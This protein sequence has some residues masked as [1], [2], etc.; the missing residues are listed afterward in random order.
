MRKRLLHCNLR[1]I[2]SSYAYCKKE[3]FVILKDFVYLLLSVIRICLLAT[4]IQEQGW[5]MI[6]LLFCSQL[7]IIRSRKELE[8]DKGCN[9]L[10]FMVQPTPKSCVEIL[11]SGTLHIFI[12]STHRKKYKFLFSAPVLLM[13]SKTI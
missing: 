4:V 2:E 12:S 7:L 13:G 10:W 11:C 8:A 3:L 9:C 1:A 5:N 6:R